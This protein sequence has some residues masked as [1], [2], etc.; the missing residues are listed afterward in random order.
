M[1]NNKK[2]IF[3]LVFFFTL[4]FGYLFLEDNFLEY[5]KFQEDKKFVEEFNSGE[6]QK[7]NKTEKK[8]QDKLIIFREKLPNLP[9]TEDLK[10][11]F[12]DENKN[13]VRDDVEIK[14]VRRF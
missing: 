9:E 6:W 11:Y 2:G 1:L 4:I 10:K 14:I 3:F 13:G 5:Q 8:Y 12:I 7:K